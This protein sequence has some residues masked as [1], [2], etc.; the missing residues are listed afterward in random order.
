[1]T[2]AI[3]QGEGCSSCTGGLGEFTYTYVENGAPASPA[4]TNDW[5]FKTVET[6]P[7]RESKNVVYANGFGEPLV[8][9][10]REPTGT[11]EI[12]TWKMY[13][14]Y[15][16]DGR[17][18][19]QA[20]TIALTSYDETAHDLIDYANPINGLADGLGLVV[21]YA[22]QVSGAADGYYKSTG[23]QQGEFGSGSIVHEITTYTERS[24]GGVT[25]VYPSKEKVFRGSAGGSE[26]V[27]DYSYTYHANV[28][29]PM[30][31]TISYDAVAETQNGSGTSITESLV[32]NEF[33][34]LIW[35]RDGSGYVTYL[36]YDLAT[37][38]LTQT[39]VDVNSY[40]GLPQQPSWPLN[41][42]GLHL[43]STHEVDFFGRMT[44]ST[45]P[46]GNVD[47]V[48]YRDVQHEVRSYGGWNS[49]TD[50]ATLP[51]VVMRFDRASG[52]SE[53]I[54]MSAAPAVSG[55]RPT[56]TESIA[57]IENW[58]RSYTNAGGQVT[59]GDQYFNLV[60][61][62][63]STSPSIGVEKLNFMRTRYSFDSRGRLERV[64]EPQ[65][66]TAGAQGTIHRY[67]FDRRSRVVA[68][69]KGTDDIPTSGIW[70]PENNTAETNLVQVYTYEYDGG[71]FGNSNLTKMVAH[72]G[73]A[74]Y[75]WNNKYDFRNRLV[76]QWRP[77]AIV[78]KY[79]YS[80]LDEITQVELYSDVDGTGN[81]GTNELRARR[82]TAST[83]LGASSD[84]LFTRSTRPSALSA[85]G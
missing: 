78:S 29:A 58:S 27:T 30:E 18:A 40:S 39:I 38:G 35:T 81:L 6:L 41:G 4:D 47:Y 56:G 51:T 70:D 63:Y 45:D 37:G 60:G 33:A 57:S 67:I 1:M 82:R 16:A 75:T 32:Y 66:E 26:S 3:L 76:E 13:T 54:V 64:E 19:L 68:Y 28:V 43:T 21:T 5:I 59:H 7:D 61:L 25:V 10:F 23:V 44:K 17:I 2:T 65:P 79:T 71:G 84:P 31:I 24:I 12:D 50:T 69:W 9:V 36:A 49:G 73:T 72:S 74:T 20:D 52:Y 11:L 55:G 14:R 22:Y 8:K 53:T 83:T 62:T 48:V 34:D 80:N 15:D 77:A 42:G 46:N 85:I